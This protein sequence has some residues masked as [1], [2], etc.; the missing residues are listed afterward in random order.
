V[1]SP[2]NPP[3]ACRFNPRCPRAQ[4]ICREVDPPLE[5]KRP[6]QMAACHFPGDPAK[7]PVTQPGKAKVATKA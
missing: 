2:I 1:P 4:D 7:Y 3:A 6:L 5:T